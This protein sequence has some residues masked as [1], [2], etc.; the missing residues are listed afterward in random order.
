MPNETLKRARITVDRI[1]RKNSLKRR[2]ESLQIISDVVEKLLKGKCTV[3]SHVGVIPDKSA[4]IKCIVE[5]LDSI[6]VAYRKP[7]F[8]LDT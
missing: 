6:K 8:S 1:K 4:C 7:P 2:R 3:H 5:A